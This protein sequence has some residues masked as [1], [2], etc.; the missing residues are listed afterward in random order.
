[1]RFIPNYIWKRTHSVNVSVR[2]L[3]S[4]NL[5]FTTLEIRMLQKYLYH[6]FCMGE[7]RGV[8]T[9]G[10]VH[11]LTVFEKKPHRQKH[12]DLRGMTRWI[13]HYKKLHTDD[14]LSGYDTPCSLAGTTIIQM[15]LSLFISFSPHQFRSFF[16][17]FCLSLFYISLFPSPSNDCKTQPDIEFGTYTKNPCC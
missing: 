5:F 15:S 11:I 9:L 1:M 2:K 7:K 14:G 8:L 17:S 10:E 16:P 4:F 6:F 3:V 13:S 12:L